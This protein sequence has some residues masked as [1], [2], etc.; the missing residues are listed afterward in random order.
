MAAVLGISAVSLPALLRAR[1]VRPR[2]VAAVS[3]AS[4]SVIG[5]VLVV[6]SAWAWAGRASALAPLPI[7]VALVDLGV[8]P[9]LL[10]VLARLTAS[11]Q[12]RA[13][14]PSKL[15][16][17]PGLLLLFQL[18]RLTAFM[19]APDWRWGAALPTYGVQHTCLSAYVRG[20]ELADTD[21]AVIYE[22]GQYSHARGVEPGFTAITGMGPYLSDP[23]HYPPTYLVV[24]GALMVVTADFARLR[25][26]WYGL[27]LLA[28]LAL[29][30]WV[31]CGLGRFEVWP[32]T[33]LG[34][35][36]L[37]VIYNLQYGQVHLLV[38][39]A[40]L[41]AM[42]A[43]R[44]DL[45]FPGRRGHLRYALGGALLAAATVTKLFPGLLLVVL[46]VG[47]Q[48]RAL[49]WTSL[50][51]ALLVAVSVAVY[52][53]MPYVVFFSEQLPKLLD[54]RAFATFQ[55][56]KEFLT[57]NLAASSLVGKLDALWAF[58]A[59]DMVARV[60]SA[61]YVLGLLL[62]AVFGARRRG[63]GQA[64]GAVDMVRLM[65]LLCL[66]SLVGAYAPGS[67]SASPFLL[68]GAWMLA[69]RPPKTGLQWLIVLALWGFFQLSPIIANLPVLWRM[70]FVHLPGAI[71]AQLAVLVLALIPLFFP[72]DTRS[73]SRMGT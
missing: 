14:V 23:Y 69:L 31:A 61:L 21:A 33:A 46:A 53:P 30:V 9:P 56:A 18:V 44:G 12:S 11:W 49:A 4:A 39:V 2:V 71:V 55:N 38:M 47:R 34:L 42:L 19:A 17:L 51:A 58:S 52:G 3:L 35:S 59:A 64:E 60:V 40:A 24:P 13:A 32:T 27:S 43:F 65:A 1:G 72:V 50:M 28:L 16:L 73:P 25:L 15:W 54:G 67:Y 57:S 70:P 62:L 20:A 37:P 48:W 26:L 68:L 22:R 63:T 5:L 7:A 45:A 36:S 66:A 10:R 8:M 41:A 6:V 29:V